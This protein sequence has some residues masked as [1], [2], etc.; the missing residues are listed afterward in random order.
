MSNLRFFFFYLIPNTDGLTNPNTLQYTNLKIIIIIKLWDNF[1]DEI[2]APKKEPYM[3]LWFH[4]Q[5]VILN[6]LMVGHTQPKLRENL[7]KF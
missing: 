4:E 5:H 7:I 3:G 1:F 2:M 6:R